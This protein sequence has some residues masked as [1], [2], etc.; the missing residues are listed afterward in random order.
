MKYLK[1]YEDIIDWEFHNM[2]KDKFIDWFEE[3]AKGTP[4]DKKRI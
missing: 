2:W 4:Y 1:T 3:N